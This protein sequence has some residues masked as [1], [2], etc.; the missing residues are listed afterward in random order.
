MQ[1]PWVHDDVPEERSIHESRAKLIGAV[2]WGVLLVVV[3]GSLALSGAGVVDLGGAGTLSTIVTVVLA[4]FAFALALPLVLKLLA[5]SRL[6]ASL[7][8]L[9]T[10]WIVG[11]FVLEREGDRVGRIE[12]LAAARETLADAT[13][14]LEELFELLDVVLGMI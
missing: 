9:G 13:E 11:R 10:S 6:L 12:E 2:L 4:T 8:L 7:A 5:I 3:V 14:P 1:N